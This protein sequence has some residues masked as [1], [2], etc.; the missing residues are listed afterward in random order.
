[1]PFTVEQ[2]LKVFAAYNQAVYPT[3]IFLVLAAFAA[4][5]FSVKPNKI[6]SKS[7]ATILSFLWIWSGIVYHLLFFSRINRFAYLFGAVFILQAAVIFYSGVVK[8]ALSFRFPFDKNGLAG[9]MILYYAVVFYPVLGYFFG[10]S[11]P[12][13]PTFGVPCPTTIFTFGLLL[14]TNKKVPFYVLIVPLLW[15]AIGSSA[16]ILFGI[17]EDLGLL[18]AGIACATLFLWRCKPRPTPA[19]AIRS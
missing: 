14:W 17:Y 12:E 11:Y 18:A 4:I 7:V 5:F 6:S 1:M 8:G 3:Q 19:G 16:A 2:F 15:A 10:H 9:T 13:A